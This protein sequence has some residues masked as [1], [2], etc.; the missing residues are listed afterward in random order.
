MQ[1]EAVVAG[2]EVDRG[3]RAAAVVLVEVGG[4]GQPGGELGERARLAPPQVPDRVPVLA[5]PLGPQRREVAHLVAALAHVPRLGD[6]LHLGD[7]RVLLH[8]VEERRQPVHLVELP[9]Q[10]RREV[11]AEA[12]D[13]H[14]GDPVPQRVHDQ[15]EHV[16]G[17]H[18]QRVPGAR[19]V[20]VVAR[21]LRQPVVRRV[22]DAFEGQ[23]RTQVV[24]LGGVVVDH[25]QDD[26]DPGLVQ[27]PDRRLELQHLL[28]AVAPGG[29]RVV[30]R[31]ETDG[32]VAPVVVQAHVDQP[33][34]VHELVHGHQFERGH[35]ELGQV[36]DDRRVGEGRVGAAQLLGEPRVTHGQ[37]LDVGL[38]DH[39]VVVLGAR[40]AVVAPVEVRVDHH[41]GHGVRRRV[42]VVAPLGRAEVVAVHLLAPPDRPADRLRVRVEQ[43][44]RGVAAQPASGVVRAVHPE[45]VP[46]SRHH[47]RHVRVPHERVALAQFHRRLR[48]VVVQQTQLYSVRGLREDREVGSGAVIGGAERIRLSRPDLHGYDSPRCAVR[49]GPPCPRVSSESEATSR[50]SRALLSGDQ[51]ARRFW[52]PPCAEPAGQI[53]T[54]GDQGE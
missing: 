28:A 18:E 2:D 24:A 15:L 52:Y 48:A 53:R 37:A 19:G 50:G 3:Q 47:A 11:E 49:R 35:P 38:V 54:P 51:C 23:R 21:V 40:R 33:V 43:Q 26:L 41:R 31:E 7:H 14:L 9:G 10:G 20:H 16:R 36:F 44:L 6:Q 46:L 34:V 22:V 32:V 13:V 39:R 12:V 1:R 5:V 45:P 25:V 42:Q 30:R 4:A 17:P 29:V 8:Q 27:R